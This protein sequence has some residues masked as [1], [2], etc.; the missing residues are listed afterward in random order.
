MEWKFVTWPNLDGPWLFNLW[1]IP[2]LWKGFTDKCR[3]LNATSIFLNNYSSR[4]I[5]PYSECVSL[6]KTQCLN[7]FD[8]NSWINPWINK[9]P[10]V[11]CFDPLFF[12]PQK[13]GPAPKFRG[14]AGTRAMT[15]M[16]PPTATAKSRSM[17][18]AGEIS[19]MPPEN[20]TALWR[21]KATAMA[22]EGVNH[23]EP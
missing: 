4:M 6:I 5:N 23:G 11:W 3:F 8:G 7:M 22:V 9:N 21:G 10:D 15:K 19:S 16:A 17:G 1:V 13:R 18:E 14:P 12:G 2:I 20:L